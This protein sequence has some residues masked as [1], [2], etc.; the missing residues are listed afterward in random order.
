MR[1][2]VAIMSG[3]HRRGRFRAVGSINAISIM[4][5]DEIDLR[6]AEIEGGELT[7]NLFAFMGGAT[8]DIPDWFSWRWAASR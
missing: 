1:W 8:I 4:G 2:M 5:G 7:I 6:E 3:S